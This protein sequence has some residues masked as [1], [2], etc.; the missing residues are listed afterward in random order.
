MSLA[1]NYLANWL[2]VVLLLRSLD[3]ERT[4]IVYLGST[5]HDPSFLSNR[6]SFHSQE[7]MELFKG[8][9]EG[10]EFLRE[11]KEEVVKGDEFPAA[12][13]RYGRSKLC[14]NLWM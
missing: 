8:G 3:G 2:L 4:R 10:L 7:M 6:A 9:E 11:A 14:C 5:S 13:R 1:L 12:V